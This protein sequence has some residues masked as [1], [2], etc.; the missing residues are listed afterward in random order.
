MKKIKNLNIGEEI[1]IKTKYEDIKAIFCEVEND[2]LKAIG[3][4]GLLYCIP[5]LLIQNIISVGG[6]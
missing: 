4:G 3:R 1:I 2:Y 6:L 5:I